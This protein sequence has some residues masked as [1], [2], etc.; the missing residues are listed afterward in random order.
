KLGLKPRTPWQAAG[1]RTEPAVSVPRAKG[2]ASA[3]TNAAD[4]ELDPAVHRAGSTGFITRPKTDSSPSRPYE[5]SWQ[6][7]LATGL[8]PASSNRDATRAEVVTAESLRTAEPIVVGYPARSMTS[9]IA[10]GLPSSC[11]LGSPP[12]SRSADWRA[13]SL[14]RKSVTAVTALKCVPALSTSAMISS[15]NCLSL[16]CGTCSSSYRQRRRRH[17]PTD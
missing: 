9:L 5:Y 17:L 2:T 16:H 1:T 7:V 13:N 15:I 10:N 14:A 4:P 3:A 8:A 6:C 11:R 12:A